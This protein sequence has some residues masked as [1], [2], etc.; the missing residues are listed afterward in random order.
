MWYDSDSGSNE[1]VSLRSPSTGKI[2]ARWPSSC[3]LKSII[4]VSPRPCFPWAEC[5]RLLRLIPVSGRCEIP[6]IDDLGSRTPHC[7]LSN[8]HQVSLKSKW[9]PLHLPSF[10]LSP[11]GAISALQSDGSLCCPC[12][13]FLTGIFPNKP[14]AHLILS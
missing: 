11:T 14:P 4:I 9:L 6:L 2:I 3:T 13:F 10:P 8:F 12:S 7:A 5:S 1:N